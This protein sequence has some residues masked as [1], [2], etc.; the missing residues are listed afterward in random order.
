M[1]LFRLQGYSFEKRFVQL[2]AKRN[3]GAFPIEEAVVEQ[4]RLFFGLYLLF[5]ACPGLVTG[6]WGLEHV[7]DYLLTIWDLV[8]NFK[9][10]AGETQKE[11]LNSFWLF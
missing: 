1:L 4:V 7:E 9:G 5:V 2:V 8:V 10:L 3:E 6:D 11:H